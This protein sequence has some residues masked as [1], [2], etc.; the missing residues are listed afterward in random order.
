LVDRR[1]QA[2]RD[3]RQRHVDD[4]GVEHFHE[5]REHDGDRDHPWIDGFHCVYTVGTTDM[6]GRSM[7]SGSCPSSSTIFTGTRCTTFTKLPVALS[8]GRRLNRAPV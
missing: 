8:G 2:A 1:R 6:P 4:G 3:V 7:C 5:G